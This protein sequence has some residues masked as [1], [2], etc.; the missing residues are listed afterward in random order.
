MFGEGIRFRLQ[1]VAQDPIRSIVLAYKVS[2]TQGTTLEEMSFD[3]GTQVDV[4]HVHRTADRYIRPYQ[5]VTYWWTI[6]TTAETSLTTE[7]Q[8][9]VYA[10][11]RFDWQ[12]LSDSIVNVHWYE[13]DARVAQQALNKAVAGLDRARQDIDVDAVDMPVDVFLYSSAEDVRSVLP[14]D[15]PL[16]TQARTL[17]GTGVILVSMGPEQDNI[18]DLARILPHEVTHA[19]IHEA[20]QSQFDHVPLWLSEGLATSIQNAAEPDPSAP[21]LVQGAARDDT[22]IPLEDLCVAFPHDPAGARLA[23][24]QSASVVDYVRDKYGR[25]ALRDLV[26]A[27]GDGASCLGGTERVLGIR[28]ERLET[29]W[30]ESLV[31]RSRWAAFWDESGAWVVLLVLFAALPL[32]FAVPSSR[33]AASSTGEQK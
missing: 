21:A 31:P 22:L 27:Y 19:L 6:Q 15:E 14:A 4:D 2:D 3:R 25:Q 8:T 24:A 11:N 5:E 10:D 29:Q 33:R 23:Y 1:V 16:D 18:P 30:R 26:A 32:A 12:T 9:F 13:G 17:Y 7:P 20:T 28:L